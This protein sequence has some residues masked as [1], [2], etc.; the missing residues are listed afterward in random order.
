MIP[1]PLL[2]RWYLIFFPF[3]PSVCVFNSHHC[4]PVSIV[5]SILYI[6]WIHYS[7]SQRVLSFSMFCNDTLKHLKWFLNQY[8]YRFVFC[9]TA[10]GRSLVVDAPP[11]KDITSFAT[12]TTT[13]YFLQSQ[14][15]YIKVT[16]ALSVLCI[17]RLLKKFVY[18][19]LNCK[20]D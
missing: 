15:L 7:I 5:R 2:G 18:I 14:S 4:Y 16:C 11:D 20:L 8:D 19:P 9:D 10:G 13:A 1:K 12:M 17:K 3:S 6:F